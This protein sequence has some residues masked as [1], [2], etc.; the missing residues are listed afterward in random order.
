M[1]YK[2][3][4]LLFIVYSFM[5]WVM[6]MLDC[7][8][9]TKRL[10]NRGFL[11]GPICPIYGAGCLLIISLLNKYMDHPIALFVLC[12]AICSIL[13][14]FTS[15]ILEKIFKIRWWDYS[16]KKYNI[17]GRICLETMIP[18]G[19]LGTLI[20]YYVNPFFTNII[21]GL[22]GTVL[23]WLYYGLLI[24]FIID[25]I[26]SLTVISNVQ[27]ITSSIVKDN[28]EEV[29]NS[30]KKIILDKLKFFKINKKESTDKKVKRILGEQGYFTKRIVDSFPKLKV[31]QKFKRKKD[32]KEEK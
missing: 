14:Y 7:W 3:Y 29:K 21:T 9:E 31:M 24:V 25:I 6:E 10:V 15:Y 17:N 18:F 8:Y 16:E 32:E 1:D 13:E 23:N 27:I 4:F 22:N 19:I 5:G 11:L 30:I 20:I 2:L 26:I 28:T 12:I